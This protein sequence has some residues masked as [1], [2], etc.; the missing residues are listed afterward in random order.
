MAH[1]PSHFLMA[2]KIISCFSPDK[3]NQDQSLQKALYYLNQALAKGFD[4]TDMNYLLFNELIQKEGLP[5]STVY[6]FLKKLVLHPRFIHKNDANHW[7]TLTTMSYL[8]GASYWFDKE[9]FKEK[10]TDKNLQTL[11]DIG[12]IL[13][14]KGFQFPDLKCIQNPEIVHYMHTYIQKVSEQQKA[15]PLLKQ[16]KNIQHS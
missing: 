11:L 15:Y 8:A 6:P 7:P 4:P 13:I 1:I 12:C 5:R 3:I 9:L 16:H 2:R 10:S 14:Q